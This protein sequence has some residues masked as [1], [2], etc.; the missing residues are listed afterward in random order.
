MRG[1]NASKELQTLVGN[2]RWWERSNCFAHPWATRVP[3]LDEVVAELRVLYPADVCQRLACTDAARLV[4]GLF[5]GEDWYDGVEEILQLGS[6]LSW[7]K[8]WRTNHQLLE[9]LRKAD[10]YEPGRFEVGVWAG[11]ARMG[12]DPHH[13]VAE[14]AAVR[15]PDFVFVD[16]GHRVA[17]ELKSLS[18]PNR[19]RNVGVLHLCLILRAGALFSHEGRSISW[20]PSPLLEQWLQGTVQSFEE[21]M[22]SRIEPAIAASLR[23]WETAGRYEVEDLG[24]VVVEG[25]GALPGGV[26]G[27]ITIAG[28][29]EGSIEQAAGRVLRCAVN[30]Q[31]QLVET[32]A[33]LRVAVIWGGLDHAPCQAIA[34]E[35]A[36]RIA[37]G[38]DLALDYIAILN[39]TWRGRRPG[40]LTEAAIVAV[41][42][43]VPPLSEMTWP[44]GI[45][46]WQRGFPLSPPESSPQRA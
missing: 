11:L 19:T 37:A 39:S 1:E 25:P 36:R 21:Q 24:T 44:Q 23:R 10:G 30:A 8:G 5:F 2:G 20:E 42:E 41:K 35:V 43:G 12:L 46:K 18:D 17:L 26:C 28:D 15:R 13:E 32:P 31:R 40:R 9:H 4:M 38:Y 16:G 29:D 27:S 22:T 6:D 14:N 34:A 33:N 3:N 45:E 7:C